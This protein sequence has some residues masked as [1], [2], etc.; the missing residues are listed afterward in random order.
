[1]QI[2]N[3][4][5]GGMDVIGELAFECIQECFLEGSSDYVG[6]LMLGRM[7][8]EAAQVIAESVYG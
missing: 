4:L 8:R 3:K 7:A 2:I 1:M 6:E 5:V